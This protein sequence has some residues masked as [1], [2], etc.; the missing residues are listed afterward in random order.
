VA[1]VRIVEH[2]RGPVANSAALASARR[3]NLNPPHDSSLFVT[4]WL[5]QI[6]ASQNGRS[7]LGASCECRI[8]T[9]CVEKLPLAQ[10][11]ML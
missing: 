4:A 11:L 9:D 6:E 8:S 1:Q 2:R 7:L 5:L 10:V 3:C